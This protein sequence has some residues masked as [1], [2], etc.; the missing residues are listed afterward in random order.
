MPSIA[1]YVISW[2][3]SLDLLWKC[4]CGAW[5]SNRVYS[6]IPAMVAVQEQREREISVHLWAYVLK[7][8]RPF[9]GNALKLGKGCE[10]CFGKARQQK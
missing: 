7:S 5:E 3:Q 8:E 1:V 4:N 6:S 10:V 2:I 9:F